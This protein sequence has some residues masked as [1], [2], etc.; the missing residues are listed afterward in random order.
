MA[1]LKD[2]MIRDMKLRNFSPKTHEAYL[3]AVT[4]LVKHYQK[5]PTAITHQE[6]EDY[7]LYMRGT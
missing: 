5:P 6:I 2:R 3:Q 7:I 1:E 4:G